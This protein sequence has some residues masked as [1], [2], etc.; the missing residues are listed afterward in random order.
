[1]NLRSIHTL[2]AVVEAG[3]ITQAAEH[4][5]SSQPAVS[6]ALR[7]L[8]DELGVVLIDRGA[9]PLRPTHAGLALYHR[10]T[11]LVADVEALALAVRSAADE[12]V[13]S[14]RIG[15]VVPCAPAMVRRLQQMA[16]E[17]EIRSGLTP[18]LMKALVAHELDVLITS[19]AADELEGVDRKLLVR[20]PFVAVLPA[21]RDVGPDELTALAAELPLVRYTARSAIG[22]A[23]ER[24]LR[25]HGIESAHRFEFDSSETVLTTVQAGLGWAIT[26]PICIAQ[27]RSDVGQLRI[28]GLP[29][30]AWR[31]LYV[32][33]RRD[34]FESSAVRIHALVADHMADA[35]RATFGAKH[36][37]H[38]AISIGGDAHDASPR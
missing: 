1:M 20:E 24:Y 30:P 15:V 29:H 16:R 28:V 27:A 11:R 26:T 19:H 3:S 18:D 25:R 2:V 10:A 23:I 35:L 6:M 12:K 36:W 13:A 32:L 8:E 21:A 7:E 22:T 4:L 34:E 17:V 5:G 37:I 33:Y 31:Q 9:R 38:D 14:L